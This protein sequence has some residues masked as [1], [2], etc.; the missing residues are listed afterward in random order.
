M[1]NELKIVAIDGGA[2]A[3][4][5]TTAR[6][7]SERLHYMHVDTGSHYRAVTLALLNAGYDSEPAPEAEFDFSEV[8]LSTAVSGLYASIEVNG[9]VPAKAELRS[10]R[11]NA[12]VSHFAA[13]PAIRRFLRDFQRGQAKFA[14]SH[15]FPGIVVEGRDIGSVIF[16]DAD[17]R[18][19]LFAGEEARASRRLAEGEADQIAERDRMDASRRTAPL[20]CPEGAI[21]INTEKLGIAAVLELTCSII[22][23]QRKP[24]S[25]YPIESAN[26]S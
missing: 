26:L 17:F 21:R 19:F 3:G 6:G 5:S 2:A 7:I 25:S 14:A 9:N 24:V 1:S 15:G 10:E 13:C 8:A 20:V 16:P 11:V 4:K 18:F 23:G 22:V 12:S